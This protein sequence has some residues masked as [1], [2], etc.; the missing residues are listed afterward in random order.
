ME[1]RKGT[2]HTTTVGGETS[3]S[4]GRQKWGDLLPRQR[5]GRRTSGT[6]GTG[7]GKVELME[8]MDSRT[9]WRAGG[10]RATEKAVGGETVWIVN[11]NFSIT[12][13]RW[14]HE[15]G[16]QSCQPSS[17]TMK[18]EGLGKCLLN[19]C[20]H[21]YIYPFYPGCVCVCG[22]GVYLHEYVHKGN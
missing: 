3:D 13:L 14:L 8:M 6:N 4:H 2:A 5:V 10:R 9:G 7:R 11:L 18:I 21:A 19:E 15:D 12:E 22:G 20:S 17:N 16:D 1:D